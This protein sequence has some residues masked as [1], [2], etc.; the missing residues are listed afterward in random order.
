M[1]DLDGVRYKY[2]VETMQE[3]GRLVHQAFV[4]VCWR[5]KPKR[6]SLAILISTVHFTQQRNI[7]EKFL[8]CTSDLLGSSLHRCTENTYVA[9]SSHFIRRSRRMFEDPIILNILLHQLSSVTAFVLVLFAYYHNVDFTAQSFNT[10]RTSNKLSAKN[11]TAV[12]QTF[13]PNK[14]LR[15]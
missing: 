8:S 7:R 9:A 5:V 2:C 4:V 13:L 3:L 11:Y 14:V 6:G 15:I 12:G 1:T 10:S